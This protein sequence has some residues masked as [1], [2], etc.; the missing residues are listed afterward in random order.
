M[1][2]CSI[3]ICVPKAVDPDR[4]LAHLRER[5]HTTLELLCNDPTNS[6]NGREC[7]APG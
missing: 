2:Y 1:Q 6:G 3:I 5:S 7:V 4:R